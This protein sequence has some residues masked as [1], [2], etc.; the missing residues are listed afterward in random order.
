M[1][2][3]LY[4]SGGAGNRGLSVR[5]NLEHF[6]NTKYMIRIYYDTESLYG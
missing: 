1:K 6:N 4:V 3:G 5:P 2:K